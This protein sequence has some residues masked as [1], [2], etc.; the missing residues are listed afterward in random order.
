MNYNSRIAAESVEPLTSDIGLDGEP[1]A[2]SRKWLW[3]GLIGLLLA[4]IAGGYYYLTNSGA[5]PLA[6]ADRDEQVPSITVIAPGRGTVE[7]VISAPGT[8]AARREMPVGVVG[9][10]GRVVSVPVEAGQWVGAGQ[11]LAVIDRA[12]Q[13]QQAQ[14]S[15]AQINVARADA[16]LAQGNLNRAEQLVE[17]GFISKAEIDRLTANRDSAAAR[18]QVARAQYN[19]LLAR[20]ARLNVV[21]P[22][23]GLVL[24]RNVEP[25]Q[26]V[27]AGSGVLFRIA[28][29][30]EME[31]QAEVGESE[32]ARLSSGV[33]ADVTPAGT[34]KIFSGQVW[35]IAP[36]I[37]PLN[38]QGQVRIALSYA[39]E[40]RPGGFATARIKSGTTNAP[41]LP[42]SAIL[43]D[44]EGSYVYIIDKDD[45]VVR[46]S[47]TL[48]IV[49][50]D[51]ITIADGLNGSERVV[52]RAGGFLTPGESVKP[53]LNKTESAPE[54]G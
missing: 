27:S 39:P 29:G 36:V 47:I 12:V 16:D 25:G 28:R 20:N 7:G 24:E 14:S 37:D 21:A 23:A 42:E 34:D 38:R 32:L 1:T 31:L 35:Q 15:R 49:T 17:R 5:T 51:G 2:K 52:L 3:F 9:E 50:P 33:Q 30:G 6:A 8:L 19:E 40:L 10:G 53:V 54:R 41:L 4:A 44:R 46:R 22:A 13:T 48:G 11:V 26:T 43:S 45:K 18:V